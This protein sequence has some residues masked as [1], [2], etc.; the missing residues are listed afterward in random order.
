MTLGS[1]LSSQMLHHLGT[2]QSGIVRVVGGM[3][4][5][6]GAVH[7]ELVLVF[8][9]PVLAAFATFGGFGGGGAGAGDGGVVFGDCG[10]GWFGHGCCLLVRG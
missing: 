7:F 1:R 8:A 9:E 5:G 2:H 4:A 10:W 3:A 6:E